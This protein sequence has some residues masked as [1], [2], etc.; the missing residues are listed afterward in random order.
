MIDA[1]KEAK[2]TANDCQRSCTEIKYT[3]SE[4]TSRLPIVLKV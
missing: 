1:L 4:R 3:V 2:H